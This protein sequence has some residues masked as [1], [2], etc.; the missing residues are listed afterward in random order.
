VREKKTKPI[1][2]RREFVTIETADKIRLE[3][4][5]A[6]PLLRF[7]AFFIDLAILVVIFLLVIYVVNLTELGNQAGG[8]FNE[9]IF[10]SLLY[11]FMVLLFFLLRWGYYLFFEMLFEGKTPGKFICGIRTIHY[12]GKPL[13]LSALILRNFA[14]IVDEL[15]FCL[16]ALVCM[17]INREYR[18]I[19][20][21]MA[22]TIV[23]KDERL[24]EFNQAFAFTLPAVSL[25]VGGAP[26]PLLHRLSE[27]ELYMLRRLLTEQARI[28]QALRPAL[29]ADLAQSVRRKIQDADR[30]QDP[31]VYLVSVFKR[32]EE[33][34]AVK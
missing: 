13:E 10:S 29:L 25:P 16:A 1:A 33:M 30:A 26:A 9:D 5:I 22:D 21:L 32:H 17:L 28:P 6:N 24:P 12:R 27:E 8:I 34:N 3:Y 31:L 14:R 23:V 15:V 11:V 18:R 7:G 19:G 20:D 2:Y 4:R